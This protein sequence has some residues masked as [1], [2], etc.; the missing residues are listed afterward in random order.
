LQFLIGVFPEFGQGFSLAHQELQADLEF[1]LQ[2]CFTF[3]LQ[4]FASTLGAWA[5]IMKAIAANITSFLMGV[6]LR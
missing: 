1:F 6:P 4:V 5:K 2:Y 3:S